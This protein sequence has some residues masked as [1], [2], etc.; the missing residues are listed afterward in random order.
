MKIELTQEELFK[1]TGSLVIL[2]KFDSSGN[3]LKELS[4][5]INKQIIENL[6]AEARKQ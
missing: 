3:E 6:K 1:V 4:E 5:K 2:S